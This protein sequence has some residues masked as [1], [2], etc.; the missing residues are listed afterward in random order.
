[1]WSLPS[2]LTNTHILAKQCDG[3][4]LAHTD[5]G[6]H[7]STDSRTNKLTNSLQG[8][9]LWILC[10]HHCPSSPVQQDSRVLLLL[11]ALHEGLP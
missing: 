11:G 3:V 9:I 6:T 10:I 7:T 2:T 1:M 4:Q 8:Q 5:G